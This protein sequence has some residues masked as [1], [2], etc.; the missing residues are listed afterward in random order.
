MRKPFGRRPCCRIHPLFPHGSRFASIRVEPLE[1]RRMLSL[2]TVNSLA[3]VVAAD[4]L[5][6]LRE[7]IQAADTNA[8]VYDAPAGSSTEPDTIQF[9]PTLFLEGGEPAARAITLAGGQFTVTDVAGLDVQ[10]P[11]AAWLTIDAHRQ[12]RVL[13][14]KGGAVADL[15]GMSLVGGS[16][17]LG[18]AIYASGSSLSLTNMAITGNM[19]TNGGGI[20]A[21]GGQIS[22]DAVTVFGNSSVSAGGAIYLTGGTL[23]LAHCEIS[24]NAVTVSS[25]SGSGGGI[26]CSGTLSLD[27]CTVSRNSVTSS[28]STSLA[29]GGIYCIGP[30]DVTD[31]IV[32]YNSLVRSNPSYPSGSSTGGGIYVSGGPVSLDSVTIC[33]NSAST[34][35]GGVYHGGTSGLSVLNSIISRNHSFSGGGIYRSGAGTFTVTNSTLS[36][37]SGR[38]IYCGSATLTVTGSTLCGNS[39]SYPGGAIYCS[40]STSLTIS[41]STLSSNSCTGDGGAIY[42]QGG[43]LNVAHCVIAQNSATAYEVSPTLGG[44]IYCYGALNLD[45]STVSGNRL[46]AGEFFSLLRG[47]GVYCSGALV[48]TDSIVDYNSA[49]F[50]YSSSSQTGVGGGIYSAGTLTMSGSTV[51][52]NSAIGTSNSRAGG[53]WA[54]GT[55]NITDCTVSEN[56]ATGS[57]GGIYADNTCVLTRVTISG[58]T[59]G[60]AGGVYAYDETLTIEDCAIVNN[61]ATLG[62]GGGVYAPD[63]V[64]KVIGSVIA[65]N[66]SAERGGGLLCENSSTTIVN[67]TIA[68]NTAATDGGGILASGSALLTNA[69]IAGNA[70]GNQGGGIHA[71]SG[72]LTAY[73][74]VV[75]LNTAAA[76]LDVYGSFDAESDYNLVGAWEYESP[77]GEHCLWGTAAAPLDPVLMAMADPSGLPSHYRPLAGS[78]LLGAGSN[79]RAIDLEGNPLST[80]Q[81]GNP[82]IVG[83]VV[84]IGA[85]EWQGVLQLVVNPSLAVEI[86]EGQAATYYVSLSEAPAAPVVVDIVKPLGASGDLFVNRTQLAFDATNWDVPQTVRILA[87]DDPEYDCDFT[88]FAFAIGADTVYVP[89]SVIDDDSQVYV[90]DSLEDVVAVDGRLTLREAVEAASA[91]LPMGDAL[92]GRADRVDR[93]TFAP[94]LAGGTIVLGGDEL[95]VSDDLQIEGLGAEVLTIDAAGLSRV[96][97]VDS[98]VEA[99]LSGMTITGGWADTG[100]ASST[101]AA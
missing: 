12:S 28:S 84:D 3:D 96:F 1:D 34:A 78:P 95:G 51:S 44:G 30:L 32:E 35:G 43:T 19:A 13:E 29:G 61:S 76:W 36:A 83:D 2:V 90:V 45:D 59:S 70:A 39:S 67:T 79:E 40:S 73:N 22:L 26:Y 86:V 56:L 72:T 10:G 46:I 48:V 9:D 71:A 31:S 92:E 64:L 52:R 18:G 77:L 24:Q 62:N 60:Y 8:A 88:V 65:G 41:N 4:G 74:T 42:F 14:V 17:S 68:G 66:S 93:I 81:I 38:G 54:G 69:T 58:N 55:S 57:A 98:D 7:A 11:G 97:R 91:N 27:D 94:E 15:S 80:D 82:R 75:A 53:V 23:S 25:S 50:S 89:V 85:V 5:I 47:G 20:Y 101:T 49:G 16:H 100:G 33:G 99:V 6:T 63:G 87:A 37:N 21:T